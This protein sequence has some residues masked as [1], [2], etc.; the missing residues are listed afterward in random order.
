MI[1][2]M[3]GAPGAGKG[4][5]AAMLS[6]RYDCPIFSTG[7][8]IRNEIAKGTDLGVRMK[9]LVDSGGLVGDEEITMLLRKNLKEC[10]TFILDG[11]PRNVEQANILSSIVDTTNMIVIHLKI[12]MALLIERLSKRIL[13]TRC[14]AVHVY[15]G[16]DFCCAKCGCQTFFQRA[17]D[18]ADSVSKRFKLYTEQT[19]QLIDFYRSKM[20]TIDASKS[21]SDVFSEITEYID[22]HGLAG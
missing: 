3:L 18:G 6:T 16:T 12:E 8:M 4:T 1:I 7:D 10:G 19:A 21:Q 20:I 2:L 17:D 14:K 15:S 13:C 5:Q 22:T 11:Y 9:T